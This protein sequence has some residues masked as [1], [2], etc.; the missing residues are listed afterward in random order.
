A[1]LAQGL[2]AALLERFKPALLGRLI[3]IP[4]Q[5]LGDA[6]IREIVE[7]KLAKIRQRVSD[8]HHALLT[9]GEELVDAIA[10]RATEVDSGA[11]NVDHILTQTLLPEMSGA[12]LERLAAGEGFARIHVTLDDSG[13]FVYRVR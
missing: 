11:R 6:E 3:V 9:Y 2:R 10:G 5:P 12:L 13:G 4:Y 8:S 1:G 7:L